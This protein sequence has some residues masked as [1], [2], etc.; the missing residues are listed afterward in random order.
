MKLLNRQNLNTFL[1]SL[2]IVSVFI[3]IRKVFITNSAYI[4]GIFSDFSALSLYLSDILV[5]LLFFFNFRAFWGGFKQLTWPSLII[6]GSL[7][8]FWLIQAVLGYHTTQYLSFYYIIRVLEILIL[9]LTISKVSFKPFPVL[10]TF[11]IIGLLESILALS[12]FSIQHSLG[13]SFF[14][15]SL[16]AIDI[17]G[18]AKIVSHGTTFI[19]P[20]GTL[21]HP[22]ILAA[23]LFTSILISV[24]LSFRKPTHKL[25]FFCAGLICSLGLLIS[26]SRAG[27]ITATIFG[28]ILL[29]TSAIK[30]SSVRKSILTYI[31]LLS[32][33]MI[34][35]SLTIKPFLLTRATI[36]DQAIMER[37]FYNHIG[38]RIL[39]QHPLSGVGIGTSLL[40]MQ[41]FSPI[42]LK[43]WQIQPI[44]NYY[45][46]MAAESGLIVAIIFLLFILWHLKK[47]LQL[48][49]KRG[50][51]YHLMLLCILA[52]FCFLMLFDHYFY[53]IVPAQILLWLIL[54]L[55]L[56]EI[57]EETKKA[58]S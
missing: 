8:I 16:L 13:L 47:L 37:T 58:S 22:N 4:T 42:K 29:I 18:V 3:P 31:L 1:I 6:T 19:R 39:E 20:Y 33:G 38:V 7:F 46:L 52:G 34:I 44:H 11:S 53:T 50:S 9:Y 41:Q 54:G 17:Q 43:P 23:F 2:L 32:F 55:A 35:F 45:L 36:A 21:P 12:Q 24:Y 40:H 27:I 56:K 25:L 51:M 14:K 15:E 57:T 48:Y 28:G 10:S 26:F 49:I 30:N 5:F